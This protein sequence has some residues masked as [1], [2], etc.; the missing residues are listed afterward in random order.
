MNNC[1]KKINSW[2]EICQLN[3]YINDELDDINKNVLS[4]LGSRFSSLDNQIFI[5]KV[6]EKL[7]CKFIDKKNLW[8]RLTLNNLN[9]NEKASLQFSYKEW[10]FYIEVITA[11]E[12]WKWNW[13]ILLDVFM[14][15]TRWK[16]VFLQDN[17]YIRDGMSDTYLRLN[18]FY[19]KRWFSDSS[20]NE[21]QKNN[22]LF[23]WNWNEWKILYKYYLDDDIID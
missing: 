1:P 4:I 16:K 2:T 13:W 12:H 3:N 18:N 21:L 22:V 20:I 8:K 15:K 17:A 23:K 11:Y 5:N 6:W 9:W 7:I 10:Y 19:K 14:K